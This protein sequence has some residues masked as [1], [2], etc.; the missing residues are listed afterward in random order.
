M[1]ESSLEALSA[2]AKN[3]PS[4]T[5]SRGS[6]PQGEVEGEVHSVHA[7]SVGDLI[8]ASQQC[9]LDTLKASSRRRRTQR[10]DSVERRADRALDLI[11]M[12]ELSAARHALEGDPI[13]PGNRQTLSALQD[14]ERRPPVPREALPASIVNLFP[15][16][17]IDL[18]Q[19]R[20]LANLRSARWQVAHQA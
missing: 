18:D 12:G 20:F 9:D 5:C 14:P 8:F 7:G 15:Q 1:S 4:Q 6:G 13:A 3:A 2:S 17:E 16:T 10:G 19:D 11:Q